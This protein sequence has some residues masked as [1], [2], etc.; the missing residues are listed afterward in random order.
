MPSGSSDAN[1]P[2]EDAIDQ[3]DDY[4]VQKYIERPLLFK[5]IKFDIRCWVLVSQVSPTLTVWMWT[6]PY[7]R[8]ASHA[9]SEDTRDVFAHLTN[10]SI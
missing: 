3:N 4:V 10:N 1:L 6:E 8:L 7:L 5:G 9:Y 2:A